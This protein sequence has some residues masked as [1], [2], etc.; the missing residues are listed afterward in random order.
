MAMASLF[1]HALHSRVAKR[2]AAMFLLCAIVPL[3]V[4][5]VMTVLHTR[6]A[7]RH[8]AQIQLHHDA[9]T[10]A[11]DAIGRLDLLAGAL[12]IFGSGVLTGA[13]DDAS[14]EAHL[15]AL[16]DPAPLAVALAASDGAVRTMR[17]RFDWPVLSAQQR[18]FLDREG[19]VLVSRRGHHPV[20]IV[21]VGSADRTDFAA[22][23]VEVGRLLRLDDGAFLPAD[24][25]AC[26]LTEGRVLACSPDVSPAIVRPIADSPVDADLSIEGE[27]DTYLGRTWLLTMDWTWGAEAWTIAMIRPERSVW[28]PITGFV[29]DFVVIAVMAALIVTWVSISQIRR[30]L[31]PIA[32]LRAATQ[33][34]AA[35]NFDEP[36]RIRSNDEFEQLGDSFNV[37]AAEL[38]EQFAALEAFSLG[39]LGTLARAIDAK[40]HWTAGHSERVTRLAV[41]IAR[42]M[43]LPGQEITELERGGLIHDIGKLGTPVEILDKPARLTP[44]E[45]RIMRLHPQAGVHILEPIPAFTPLLPIVGQHHE[46][47]DGTGY[48]NGLSGEHIA[49]TAR[50]LAVA[51]VFDAMRSDR[52]YRAGLPL[53]AVVDAIT[54]GAGTHFDPDVVAG[55]LDVVPAIDLILAQPETCDEMVAS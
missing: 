49:R 46:R 15:T 38:R 8:Q 25:H 17:G 22:G 35:R 10:V 27:D 24:S 52:P 21:R 53:D 50:V 13:V 3:A 47:W 40:S 48:P 11:N 7:L 45:E 2:V 29:R 19:R 44:E 32:S 43:G 9:K 12:R 33:R 26:V 37:L 55:F 31:R 23:T 6:E 14:A 4:L 18:R 54:T 41:A 36:V 5:A 28:A 39:T 42:A 51:D 30:Q 1:E 34:L 16:I 20:M